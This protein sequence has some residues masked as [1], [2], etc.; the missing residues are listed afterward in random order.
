MLADNTDVEHISDNKRNKIKIHIL[1]DFAARNRA[2]HRH[3]QKNEHIL[4]HGTLHTRRRSA[5]YVGRHVG[6]CE[7]AVSLSHLCRF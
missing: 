3:F 2:R 4:T 1:S 6:Q 7:G 5:Q